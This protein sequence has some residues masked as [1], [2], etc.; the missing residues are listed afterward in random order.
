M[1]PS[2]LRPALGLTAILLVVFIMYRKSAN[3]SSSQKN[4][5][6]VLTVTAAARLAEHTKKS[7]LLVKGLLR[8][9]LKNGAIFLLDEDSVNTNAQPFVCRFTI[10]EVAKLESLVADTELVI[11]GYP[12]DPG[13]ALHHCT[14]ISINNG[15]VSADPFPGH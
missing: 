10:E 6:K 8:K 15:T 5:G 12:G 4:A 13:A 7:P 9:D 14:I 11:E 1:K 3:G 2:I